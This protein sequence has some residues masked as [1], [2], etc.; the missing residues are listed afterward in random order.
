MLPT[1]AGQFANNAGH[2]QCEIC[3]CLSSTQYMVFQSFATAFM[4]NPRGATTGRGVL[5]VATP[6]VRR[7]GMYR[8]HT[9]LESAECLR[10]I[11]SP[12]KV[13]E[14]CVACGKDN[15]A[16][17][18][19]WEGMAAPRFCNNEDPREPRAEPVP[20]QWGEEGKVRCQCKSR[21]YGYSG[22]PAKTR[23]ANLTNGETL[24][25]LI[26][27]RCPRGGASTTRLLAR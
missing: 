24:T 13:A 23:V 20:L 25:S 19:P 18:C 10:Q 14:A 22:N 8:D 27:A 3:R 2:S 6:L 15:E 7:P 1:Q 26:C 4:P 11:G 12:C 5:L 16:E 17:V 21:F 9:A